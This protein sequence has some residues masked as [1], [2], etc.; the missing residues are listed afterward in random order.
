M[1]FRILPVMVWALTGTLIGTATALFEGVKINWLA[2]SLVLTISALVQG[3]PTHIINEI[4]DW[5]SGAD[6]KTLGDKKSGGSK[7]IQAGLL[8][9]RELWTAFV[10]TNAILLA[11]SAVAAR[12][13]N[14]ELIVFFVVPGYLSGVLYTL[15]P[16]R[17]AY[18]PFLGEWFGGFAGM[19][20]LVAGSYYAQT[21]NLSLFAIGIAASVGLIYIAIMVYFH[22][23]DHDNDRASIPRKNTTVV[24]LGYEGCRTY[25]Y[26]CLLL[27]AIILLSFGFTV[28]AESLLLLPL[29]AVVLSSHLRADLT[30]ASSIIRFG[31]TITMA[32]LAVGVAFAVLAEPA[33][34]GMIVV[35]A[36]GF[37]AHKKFGK[38]ST[39]RAQ[40]H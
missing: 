19:F 28:R 4:F 33:F 10:I 5:K 20:L 16:F 23:L 7:V 6:G 30:Q 34:A 36:L 40:V 24:F 3:Y 35:I 31:R 26:A 29:V 18:R 14:L 1:L 9:V 37:L 21:P 13:I 2:F 12:H 38:L 8:S 22:Y 17:F 27:S 39:L 25:A 11:L 15:P 32:V